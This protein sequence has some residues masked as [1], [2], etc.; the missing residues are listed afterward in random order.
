M[1]PDRTAEL[2]QAIADAGTFETLEEAAGDELMRLW[3]DLYS[4]MRYARDG[5]WSVGC[6]YI[7]SRIVTLT[8][9]LGR[10]ARWQDMPLNLLENG[11][12]QRMHDLLGMAY[13]PPDMDAVARSRAL[14]QEAR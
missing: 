3:H 2:R 6:E 7:V 10:P 8:R 9:A 11:I 13:E 5:C 4:Q 14:L 1:S 12:Y